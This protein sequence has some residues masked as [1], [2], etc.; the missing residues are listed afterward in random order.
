MELRQRVRLGGLEQE[1]L[2][3]GADAGNPLLLV[4]HGGP[5]F[6]EMPLF[7]TYNADL[8]Q[9]FL[10]VYWDQ[11]GA[12]RSYS[13]DIPAGTM[14]L[15]QFVSDALEL[16]DWLCE[17]FG[18][19]KVHLLGHSWGSLVGATLAGRHPARLHAFIGVGQFV[20][21]LRNEQLSYAFTL[22]KAIEHENTE[23]IQ[24]L[25]AIEDRYT[26][27][28]GLTFADIVV[29]R[30]WLDRYGGQ[31]HGDTGALFGRIEPPLRDE[32]YGEASAPSQ[33]FSFAHLLPDL[34]ATDLRRTVRT[35][36]IPVHFV[37]GRH[38]QNTPVEL[39]EEYFELIEAP[40]KRLHWFEKSAHMIP[41]EEPAKFNA[42]LA[43]I[44]RG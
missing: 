38:D 21:G 16:I 13:P 32:Y 29:Q 43:E 35:F 36:G 3:R 6:A 11:R 15:E 7:T 37:L 40:V 24:A 25:R 23:A 18:Q 39:A 14:T 5:G 26:S 28:G 34:L 12:G 10:M 20:A 31:V 19:D 44:A 42:L 2:V 30:G 4:L 22:R 27:S 9:H 8:E 41:F 17:R 1:V 33:E